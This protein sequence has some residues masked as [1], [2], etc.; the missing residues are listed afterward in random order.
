VRKYGTKGD[1]LG[2][3][4]A[5]AAAVY[6]TLTRSVIFCSQTIHKQSGQP[7]SSCTCGLFL[8]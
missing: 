8:Q 2:P 7:G 1:A 5:E 6:L 3:H 4:R